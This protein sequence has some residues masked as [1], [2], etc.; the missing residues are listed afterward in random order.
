M[1]CVG[2]LCIACV[3][4]L[5]SSGIRFGHLIW[6]LLQ[7]NK[8]I[9]IGWMGLWPRN[10]FKSCQRS[11]HD[12]CCKEV[13]SSLQPGTDLGVSWFSVLEMRLFLSAKPRLCTLDPRLMLSDP[14]AANDI[15]EKCKAQRQVPSELHLTASQISWVWEKEMQRMKRTVTWQRWTSTS[16]TKSGDQWRDSDSLNLYLYSYIKK[17]D[18]L[19]NTKK[20]ERFSLLGHTYAF[21]ARALGIQGLVTSVPK[22]SKYSVSFVH[23]QCS[24]IN[25]VSCFTVWSKVRE[26]AKTHPAGISGSSGVLQVCE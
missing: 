13:Y 8:G 9:W 20:C 12:C 15:Q 22:C 11:T 6:F 19:I 26:V 24:Y 21:W 2:V 25:D 18:Q 7:L 4:S 14:Q 5:H 16:G 3:E 17:L 10:L 23:K 1:E